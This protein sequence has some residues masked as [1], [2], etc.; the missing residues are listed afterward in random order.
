[1]AYSGKNF[2]NPC[3]A[4]QTVKSMKMNFMN[5]SIA[6]CNSF[7]KVSLK[8]GVMKKYLFGLRAML[9]GAG[10]MLVLIHLEV[11]AKVFGDQMSVTLLNDVH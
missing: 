9:A 5:L 10:L 1:M 8:E 11:S 6:Y 4:T 3:S 7:N 2:I